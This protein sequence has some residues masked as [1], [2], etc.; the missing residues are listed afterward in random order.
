LR[1]EGILV[2]GSLEALHLLP[3][4]LVLLFQ[5]Q[6]KDLAPLDLLLRNE[7]YCFDGHPAAVPQVLPKV[8]N[9]EVGDS[10]VRRTGIDGGGV[11][12]LG[13]SNILKGLQGLSKRGGRSLHRAP[14]EAVAP[15]VV[16]KGL[17]KTKKKK[18]KV[19]VDGLGPGG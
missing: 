12:S 17:K 19:R 11:S 7:L 6:G 3:Q 8:G 9:Y 10:L 13:P 15:E 18:R 1:G 5:G 4:V 16:N 2:G 14:P